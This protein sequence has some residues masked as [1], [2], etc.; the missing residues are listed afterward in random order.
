M[1]PEESLNVRLFKLTRKSL[2]LTPTYLWRGRGKC[3]IY[4]N[5]WFVALC[6]LI[7][8]RTI[9]HMFV[10]YVAYVPELCS[11]SSCTVWPRFLHFVKYILALCC[12]RSCNLC[13]FLHFVTYV[14][15]L[16]GVCSTLCG[17]R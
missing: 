14:P 15:L 10:H 3:I 5:C 11:Q 1:H 8:K 16:C 6:S 13:L 17:V 7:I 12:V 9:W 4:S 2:S